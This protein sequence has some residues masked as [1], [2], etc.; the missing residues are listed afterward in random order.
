MKQNHRFVGLGP[1]CIAAVGW[2][3]LILFSCAHCPDGSAWSSESQSMYPENGEP[4]ASSDRFEARASETAPADVVS[5]G[6]SSPLSLT[7]QDTLLMALENNVGFQ[8]ERLQPKVAET[9]VQIESAVFDPVFFR[10]F[11]RKRCP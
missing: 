2:L 3:F 7:L 1:V 5:E 9:Q 11:G 10:W 4:P 8:I 6:D